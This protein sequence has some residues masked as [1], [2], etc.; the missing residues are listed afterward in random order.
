MSCRAPAEERQAL[1]PQLRQ[2]IYPGHAPDFSGT[3][4]TSAACTVSR[5][6]RDF[7]Y[8]EK[9]NAIAFVQAHVMRDTGCAALH[10]VVLLG[11]GLCGSRMHR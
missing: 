4:R 2:S 10:G 11:E 8:I 1:L 3:E 9:S 6:E 5:R 7:A